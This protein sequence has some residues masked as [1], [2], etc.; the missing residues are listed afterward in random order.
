MA[1]LPDDDGTATHPFSLQYLAL[2][3]SRV[4]R[5]T[6]RD[7]NSL[8]GIDAWK[9]SV[10]FYNFYKDFDRE[11]LLHEVGALTDMVVHL[12]VVSKTSPAM[13]ASLQQVLLACIASEEFPTDTVLAALKE[14]ELYIAGL[15]RP[16]QECAAAFTDQIEAILSSLESSSSGESSKFEYLGAFVDVEAFDRLLSALRLSTVNVAHAHVTL[17]HSKRRHLSSAFAVLYELMGHRVSVTVRLRF[18]VAH[19]VARLLT[20]S[21]GRCR[22]R[23]VGRRTNCVACEFNASIWGG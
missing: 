15:A 14:H 2:C 19:R 17:W 10:M 4:V 11:R 1:A 5:R 16:F 12:P 21:S 7:H 13:P 9:V 6:S 18:P 3:L 8:F 20:R 23:L 22:V